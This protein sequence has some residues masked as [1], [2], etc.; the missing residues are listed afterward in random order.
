MDYYFG[1]F[2]MKNFY[3][4]IIKIFLGESEFNNK[5]R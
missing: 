3:D 4:L 5:E 2:L 1:G